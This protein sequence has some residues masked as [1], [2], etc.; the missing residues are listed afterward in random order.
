M[1]VKGHF[2]DLFVTEGLYQPPVIRN[3]DM[4]IEVENLGLMK[5]HPLNDTGELKFVP[6]SKLIFHDVVSSERVIDKYEVDRFTIKKNE[7]SNLITIK[8]GPFSDNAASQINEYGL[9]GVLL[10]PEA[11]IRD[12]IIKARDFELEVLS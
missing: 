6:K 12:W 8:D 9:E 1:K 11:W 3:S 2:E 10:E 5:T 7:Q 4:L